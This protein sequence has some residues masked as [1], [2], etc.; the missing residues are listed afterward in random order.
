MLPKES[1]KT[2]LLMS[3]KNQYVLDLE[4]V[5]TGSAI[6][7]AFPSLVRLAAHLPI[8]LSKNAA[9]VG[10]RLGQYAT[11]SI[12]RYKRLIAADP[13]NPKPT[14]FTK[15][16][17]GGENGLTDTEIRLEATGYVFAGS[18]TTAV[19]LTYLIWAV[20]QDQSVREKLAAE[21]SELPE[22][23][24][25][26]NLKELPYLNQVIHETLRLY[27]AVPSALPRTFPP[28]GANLAGVS[29]PGGVTVSTQAY[30]LHRD[31]NCV[32]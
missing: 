6:R 10:A 8:P 18:D 7:I 27:P 15:V 3:Q 14:L 25:D 17:N 23:F 1:D 13:N 30:T 12:E 21:V 5:S 26:S 20:C 19:T 16:F 4:A 11:E 9:L 29:L 32:P 24:N 22:A 31:P 28:E 2:Q